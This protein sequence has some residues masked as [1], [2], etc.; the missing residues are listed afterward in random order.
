[1]KILKTN[2]KSPKNIKSISLWKHMLRKH[3][4]RQD[5]L[6]EQ[7]DSDSAYLE[8]EVITQSKARFLSLTPYCFPL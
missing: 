4:E 5:T 3:I 8:D 7:H 6:N 2:T 1:M